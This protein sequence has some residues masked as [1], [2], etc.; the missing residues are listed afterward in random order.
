LEKHNSKYS[1]HS[2]HSK[3]LNNMHMIITS[4]IDRSVLHLDLDTFFVSVERLRNS[5]LNG[6]PVIIGGMSDRGVVSSC[7][8]EARKYGVSSAMPMKEYVS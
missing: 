7:S 3:L 5:K 1:R 6:M 8:Y 2:R 4:N